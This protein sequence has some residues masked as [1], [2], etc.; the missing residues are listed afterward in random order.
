MSDKILLLMNNNMINDV[1][2]VDYD[3]PTCGG[4]SLSVNNEIVLEQFIEIVGSSVC[5]YT[6]KLDKNYI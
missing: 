5:I 4:F 3:Q 6:G 2:E 1:D